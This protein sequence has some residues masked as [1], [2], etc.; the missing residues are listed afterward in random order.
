MESTLNVIDRLDLQS[1]FATHYARV[2]RTIALV[3]G[4][5]G[6]AEELAVEVFLRWDREQNAHPEGWLYKTAANLAI[7]EL[8]ARTRRER[9]SRF[10][11]WRRPPD[12]PEEIHAAKQARDGVRAVLARM[13]PREAALLLLRTEGFSYEELAAALGLNPASVGTLLSRAQ[14][15]FRKEY[16]ARYG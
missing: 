1:V 6:R 13:K 5:C 8:R 10:L 4:D 7:D 3:L 16:L 9:L 11:P 14:Q 15:T 2:A 12:T